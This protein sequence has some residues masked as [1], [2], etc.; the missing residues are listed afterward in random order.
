MD[1]EWAPLA[2]RHG[3]GFMTG[4]GTRMNSTIQ[5]DTSEAVR[6]AL[7]RARWLHWALVV[8]ILFLALGTLQNGARLQTMKARDAESRR[9]LLLGDARQAREHGVQGWYWIARTNIDAARRIR[10][11][12][13]LRDEW[14]ACVVQ[15]ASQQASDPIPCRLLGW[16]PVL[17]R[18]TL[19][20]RWS[21][22]GLAL[23]ACTERE[24]F[25]WGVHNPLAAPRMI[26]GPSEI[27]G[28]LFEA[29]DR[30]GGL[31]ASISPAG[32]VR[33]Q[34]DAGGLPVVNLRGPAEHRV[35]TLAWSPDGN[36]LAV[37]GIAAASPGSMTKVLELWNLPALRRGLAELDLDWSDSEPG[38]SL[39]TPE[40]PDRWIKVARVLLGALLVL[41]VAVAAIANQHL[42]FRRYEQ[43][44]RAA[45]ARAMELGLVRDRMTHA[46]KMRALGTLA[47]GVAHD[48]NNLLSVIQMSR[49]L[50]ERAIKPT[51]A[52]REHL[53]NIALAVEQGRA[54]V[55]SILGYS[56][57]SRDLTQPCS[58]PELMEGVL[59][60]LRRQFL[61][62]IKVTVDLAP[63]LPVPE[64]RRGRLEQVLLNLIVNAGEAMG[65]AGRLVLRARRIEVAG[66]CLRPPGG[67]GPWIE[68]SV[69][70][71]GPG[72]SPEILP[73]VFEPFFTTK[74]LGNQRG[75]GLGLAT[76]WRIAEEEGLGLRLR[77]ATGKGT[78]FQ[79]LIPLQRSGTAAHAAAEEPTSAGLPGA[80]QGS[81][82]ARTD[83]TS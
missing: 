46:E 12:P 79:L 3:I 82:G 7:R 83:P 47:A 41:A 4:N 23:L 36:W 68:L 49:Q 11:G 72:I 10:S 1:G 75:T 27:P 64:A 80:P 57:D 63:D 55:R 65:R 51:G 74:T 26:S 81:P 32:T 37:A 6:R 45:E 16:P 28:R 30:L 58:I 17:R 48:F 44:E 59:G 20:F 77:T 34:T 62:G 54:V 2:H 5:P 71:S 22:D 50:V 43:A 24:W 33:I 60:L 19:N 18:S 70:D 76:V 69:A 35:R 67:D 13:D 14:L 29:T 15:A 66:Q 56:R 42:V 38:G 61:A 31:H 73:R 40:D 39:R 78:E 52:T 53:D 25:R 9:L 8:L 21:D